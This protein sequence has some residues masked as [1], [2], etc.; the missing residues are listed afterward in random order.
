L[1][2]DYTETSPLGRAEWV[3]FTAMFFNREGDANTLFDE[4]A[5]NYDELTEL[6]ATVE[7]RPTVLVNGM[8]SDIWYISG[9]NSFTARMIED[10]GGDFL[11][12]DDESI[13][14]LALSFEA[15][16]DRAQ[17]A[18]F[19]LNANF[20]FSLDEGLAED[21][22]Y[23]EFAAFQNQR[24][25]NNNLRVNETGGNDYGESGVLRPDQVLTD[26]ISIFHPDLLPDHELFYYRHLE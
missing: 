9:G 18:D 21:E 4:I 3:K 5:A 15:V 26:L 25:Y 19:W 12:S 14:S 13:A 11:W 7:T 16:F 6:T 10:A 2:A 17:S 20:W 22:R 23:S 1:N 8:F 24:V